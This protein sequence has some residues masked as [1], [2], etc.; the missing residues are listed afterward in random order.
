MKPS[1]RNPEAG[2]I[3][4]R[5]RLRRDRLGAPLLRDAFPRVGQ[6][7]LDLRFAGEGAGAP[8]A[9]TH[10]M[11]PSA[12]AFFDFPCPFGDCAG[13]FEL[14]PPVSELEVRSG[15]ERRG[16]LECSGVRDRDRIAGNDRYC[17]LHLD[18]KIT[19][20]YAAAVKSAS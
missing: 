5:E 1:P 14:L 7:R 13:R 3:D 9:Q 16:T 4:R 10:V 17:G 2:R 12:R 15:H 8:T 19:V 11:Y 6:V 20:E 18:F